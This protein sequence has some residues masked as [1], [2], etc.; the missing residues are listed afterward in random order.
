MNTMGECD[1]LIKHKEFQF[2]SPVIKAVD[3]AHDC[4]IGMNVLVMWPTMRYAIDVLMKARL[5]D[6]EKNS[7]FEPDSTATRLRNICKN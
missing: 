3:L 4:L 2:L 7:R 5:S 6:E 1:V